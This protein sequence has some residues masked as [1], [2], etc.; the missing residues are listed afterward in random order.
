MKPEPR[1]IQIEPWK[2]QIFKIMTGNATLTARQISALNIDTDGE[3]LRN[4]FLY[5]LI[6]SIVALLWRAI[7]ASQ[8]LRF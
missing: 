4:R 8:N 2:L 1:N 6:H 5:R 7:K 3:E